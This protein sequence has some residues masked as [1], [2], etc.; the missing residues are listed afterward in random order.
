MN[1]RQWLDVYANK[2]GTSAP[3]TDEF[4]AVLDLAGEAAH[5][6]ERVRGPG[7]LLAGG[8]G[9][10]RTRGGVRA[11]AR[12]ERSRWLIASTKWWCSG[13]RDSRGADRR[14]PRAPR[15]PRSAVALA[16][17]NHAKLEQVRSRLAV[18]ESTSADLTLLRGRRGR[19]GLDPG[20]GGG[21]EVVITTVGPYLLYGEPLV[22]ACAAAGTDY[23]DLTGEP[24][25]VD[26]MWLRYHERAR[27]TGARI[28]HS[29]G[30][31]SIPYD[32][33]ALFTVQ[34]LPEGVPIRSRD[35]CRRRAPSR[36]GRIT[37]PSTRLEVAPGR[38][39]ARERRPREPRPDGATREGIAGQAPPRP[40]GRRMGAPVSDDRPADRLALGPRRCDALRPGLQ[41][42]PLPGR[43]TIA[44]S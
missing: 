11:S 42:Q 28:V 25:F 12:G 8:E 1:A 34:Q 44:G 41:L 21:D 14:V 26:R 3:S 10:D 6:S 20:G 33:G 9:R 16:G 35:S 22:A 31:D 37:R 30:F 2:L 4:T 43:Q 39:A 23:V 38:A 5:S 29:C 15:A 13:P 18:I 32:L 36:A 27:E 24:E 19:P 7:G 40:S 17:R